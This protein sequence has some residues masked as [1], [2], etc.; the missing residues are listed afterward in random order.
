[1]PKVENL[2]SVG[3]SLANWRI[4]PNGGEVISP[5]GQRGTSLPADVAFSPRAKR[6][7]DQGLIAIEGYTA[8]GP[9]SA[10]IIVKTAPKVREVVETKP[11]LAAKPMGGADAERPTEDTKSTKTLKSKKG[12]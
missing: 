8:G 2:T 11:A 6:M 12:K 10:K 5:T 1:M 4:L 9:K 7:A 3:V